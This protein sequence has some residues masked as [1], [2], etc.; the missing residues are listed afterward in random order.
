M[1]PSSRV[2]SPFRPHLQFMLWCVNHSQVTKAVTPL[3]V[4]TTANIKECI[5]RNLRCL[6]FRIFQQDWP[7]P[8]LIWPGVRQTSQLTYANVLKSRPKQ[9]TRI[10]L[11]T[12]SRKKIFSIHPWYQV[13]L[14]GTETN[15]CYVQKLAPDT[16][17]EQL[18]LSHRLSQQQGDESNL[19]FCMKILMLI[20]SNNYFQLPLTAPPPTCKASSCDNIGW[21]SYIPKCLD[22]LSTD[23][24][25]SSNTTR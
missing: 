19:S 7:W 14:G 2:I 13:P 10:M 12:Y 9:E 21:Q 3:S 6:W 18:T 23:P 17:A 20:F 25:T 16:K 8:Q 11:M 24:K 5:T 15:L 22:M 4:S 1:F